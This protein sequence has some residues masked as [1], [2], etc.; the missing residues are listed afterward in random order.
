MFSRSIH[1][2][3]PK[4]AELTIVDGFLVIL[5]KGEIILIVA[6]FARFPTTNTMYIPQ[7]VVVLKFFIF[8]K[9]QIINFLSNSTI[10]LCLK[11]NALM[12]AKINKFDK[13]FPKYSFWRTQKLIYEKNR[14]VKFSQI[15]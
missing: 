8:I 10:G 6:F 12:R 7:L 14:N 5:P 2:T 9:G 1:I 4:Q 13:I 3:M 11:I 15:L